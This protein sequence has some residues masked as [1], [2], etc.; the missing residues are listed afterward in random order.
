MRRGGDRRAR[1]VPGRVQSTDP[2]DRRPKYEKGAPACRRAA[3]V[4]PNHSRSRVDLRLPRTG[5]STPECGRR[6][7]ARTPDCAP[8]VHDPRHLSITAERR[9]PASSARIAGAAVR[10]R[11]DQSEPRRRPRAGWWRTPQEGNRRLVTAGDRL[12]REVGCVSQPACGGR[13][14]VRQFAIVN[15]DSGRAFRTEREH[16]TILS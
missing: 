10:R 8:A 2:T 3:G 6:A 14:D 4:V 1:H 7:F 11:A 15:E 13:V 12:P 9:R 5:V 16:P